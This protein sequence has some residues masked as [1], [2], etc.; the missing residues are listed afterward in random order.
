MC[1][2]F[3]Y[4]RDAQVHS[5]LSALTSPVPCCSFQN[6]CVCFL[7]FLASYRVIFQVVQ[8][9]T[10]AQSPVSIVVKISS[11]WFLLVVAVCKLYEYGYSSRGLK[12]LPAHSLCF[13]CSVF[14]CTV[15]NVMISMFSLHYLRRWRNVQDDN[16]D[17]QSCL[18]SQ[19]IYLC[20]WNASTFIKNATKFFSTIFCFCFTAYVTC[21]FALQYKFFYHR[22][23]K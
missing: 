22:S 17:G 19:T 21:F 2:K 12:I 9:N 14:H 6:N 5:L 23:W 8:E 16:H 13:L 11:C 7:T 3:L 20:I 18:H 1:L 10:F 4:F 15:G